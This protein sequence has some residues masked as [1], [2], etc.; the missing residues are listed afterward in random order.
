MHSVKSF[1]ALY[2][3]IYDYELQYERQ[4]SYHLYPDLKKEHIFRIRNLFI[5]SFHFQIG[6]K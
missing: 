4:S 3:T 1:T 6:R 5:L 2:I